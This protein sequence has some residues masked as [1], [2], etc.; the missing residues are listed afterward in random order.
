MDR[1]EGDRGIEK[2]RGPPRDPAMGKWV[3]WKTPVIPARGG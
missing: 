1:E 2:V 3:W